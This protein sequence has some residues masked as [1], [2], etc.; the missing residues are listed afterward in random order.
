MEAHK[1]HRNAP[2]CPTALYRRCYRA[3]FLNTM[4][5]YVFEF[6]Y[7]D[8]QMTYFRGAV[9]VYDGASFYFETCKVVRQNKLKALED[10]KKLIAKL[11]KKV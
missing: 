3:T 5:P 2:K 1:H 4:K 6:K 7:P 11:K 8:K 10:S 9:K